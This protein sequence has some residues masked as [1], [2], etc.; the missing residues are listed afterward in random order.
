MN[1]EEELMKISLI[2]CPPEHVSSDYKDGYLIFN[3]S[4]NVTYDWVKIFHE[5]NFNYRSFLGYGPEKFEFNYNVAQIH[6]GSTFTEAKQLL[7]Y[8][9]D[10]LVKTNE[11]YK[12]L[13]V[14][15]IEYRIRQQ[16]EQEKQ[17]IEEQ[18]RREEILKQL[19][20]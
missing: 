14:A 3:L 8:F 19:N 1:I 10:Y 4:N 18:R 15:E 13:K 20:S 5:H 6:I 2:K 7:E 16:Q 11:K 17:I 12:E 9:K